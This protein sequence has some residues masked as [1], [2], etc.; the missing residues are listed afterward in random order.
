M[1]VIRP[2]TV[3]LSS[4]LLFGVAGLA[5]LEAVVEV[6]FVTTDLNTYREAYTGETSSTFA[7]LTS[8][9]LDLFFAA[10]VCILAFLTNQGRNNARVV[11]LVLGGLFLFCGGFGSLSDGLHRPSRSAGVGTLAEVMP[12]AYGIG[13]GIVDVL[14]VLMTL[15]A[16]VLLA[17]PPS[18][19]FFQ[20]P[21]PGAFP[22]PQPATYP[23][24]PV[25]YGPPTPPGGYGS[26]TPLVGYA[27]QTPLPMPEQA[28]HTGSIPAIDP[29]ADH[30]DRS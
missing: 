20:A 4:A 11:T 24:P 3:R 10:G 1:R 30:E 27:S 26:P 16:L 14:T 25:G 18:N 9:T 5:L 6:V 22:A 19:R 8:F 23:H 7:S 28:P 29:W 21:Q 15:G 2:F 17:L 13:I 12:A